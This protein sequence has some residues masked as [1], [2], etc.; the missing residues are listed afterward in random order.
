[1]PRRLLERAR[2]DS[3]REFRAAARARFADGLA[4]AGAGR[5]TGAIYLWGYSAE[6]TLKAAFFTLTG[7]GET[8]PITWS[9]ELQPAIE[10]GRKVYNI[11]WPKPGAGH[12]VRA[13]SELLV[14]EWSARGA[15]YPL[16][17]RHAVQR[18]GTRIGM[19]WRETLCY[20]QNVAYSHEVGRVREAAEWL[21]THVSQL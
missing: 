13:W 1:M 19:L 5:R 8:D 17:F 9:G 7:V 15:P 16:R 2:P 10:H 6:M 21:L 4:L 20:D 11:H 12:N 14:A 18:R 3:V